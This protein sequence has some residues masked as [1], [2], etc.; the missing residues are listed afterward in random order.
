MFL[1][2]QAMAV[3]QCVASRSMSYSVVFSTTWCDREK[4]RPSEDCRQTET[5]TERQTDSHAGRGI[6][7]PRKELR[8]CDGGRLGAGGRAGL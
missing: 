2:W 5:E 7:E 4:D 6:Q 8:S 3:W 1:S